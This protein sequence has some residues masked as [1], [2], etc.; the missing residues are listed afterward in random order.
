MKKQATE[1][2]QQDI[3]TKQ[4]V[5][6][7]QSEEVVLEEKN[8]ASNNT[9][10][11]NDTTDKRGTLKR[12]WM[13]FLQQSIYVLTITSVGV[14]L[15]TI[16]V[17]FM[18]IAENRSNIIELNLTS[19]DIVKITQSAKSEE[20]SQIEKSLQKVEREPKASIMNKAVA[21]AY[22]LQ[23]VGK[24]DDA[25]EKWHSIANIAEGV[26][27]DLA[28][29]AWFAVG[30]L[31]HKEGDTDRA[32]LAYD[33]AIQLKPD[34]AEAYA[35]RG[36]L[37]SDLGKYESAIEDY[38]KAIHLNLNYAKAYVD[39][40]NAK[41]EQGDY[42]SAL[43]D[44]NE[45]IRLEPDH[46]ETYVIRGRAKAERGDYESAFADYDVAIR[47]E[48]DY[49]EAYYNRGI[50]LSK[51]NRHT[52]AIMDYDRVIMLKPDNAK[53]YTNRGNAKVVLRKLESARADF[54]RA[55]E[56]AEHHGEEDIK[57]YVEQ[58]IQDLNGTE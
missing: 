20:L 41:L 2:E 4:T 11:E 50:A 22:R 26:D 51:I 43:A 49:A 37:M 27:N 18:G 42:E 1:R 8:S 5:E 30:D 33:K 23:Q 35:Y 31:Y 16:G 46:V 10:G 53:A 13:F 6:S 9:I 56:L 12:V 15:V 24:I 54:Q 45:A 40:G 38:K 17:L 55:L 44:Y 21:D 34:Y 39:R 36:T 57:V 29:G 32:L 7:E 28:A 52:A 3:E 47:L 58:R 19:E 48:P 14:V 25:I